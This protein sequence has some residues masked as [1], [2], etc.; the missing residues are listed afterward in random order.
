VGSKL[1]LLPCAAGVG[2][3]LAYRFLQM[4]GGR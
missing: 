3:I 4:F 2:M 1:R